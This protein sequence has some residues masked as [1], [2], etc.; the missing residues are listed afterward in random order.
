MGYWARWTITVVLTAAVLSAASSVLNILILV[1]I[2]AVLAVGLDPFVRL[3]ERAGMRRGLAVML[4]FVIALGFLAAFAALV[5]PPLVREIGGLSNDIPK[6]AARLQTRQDWIGDFVRK[7]DLSTKL[8]DA[9]AKIPQQVS[10]SFGTILGITGQVASAVFNLLTIAILTIYFLSALPRLNRFTGA[11]FAPERRERGERIV[12]E[13]LT[14]IGGFVTGNLLTS[15]IAGVTSLVALVALGIPFAVALAMWVAIADLIPAVGA[16]LGA[17]PAVIVAFFSSPLDGGATL[18]FFIVYQ[19]VENYYIVPRVMKNAV[20]LSPA[21]VIISTLIG[22]SLAGFAGALL[23]LPVAATIKVIVNDV[24][25]RDRLA[26]TDPPAAPPAAE[27]PL[28][29]DGADRTA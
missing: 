23:A 19:Q 9:A 1:V 2:A 7:N 16:T 20:D 6:Y 24:W 13:S 11:L 25:I 5:I 22:G 4:I 17:V 8:K 14:K 10:H 26:H 18:S 15:L 3:L 12:A 27:M 21:A 28:E 29:A